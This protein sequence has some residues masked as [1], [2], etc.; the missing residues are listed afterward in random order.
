MKSIFIIIFLFQVSLFSSAKDS[1][2]Y[3][4]FYNLQNLFDTEDDPLTDDSEFLPDSELQWT[5]ERLD[6]QMFNLARVIR[7]MNNGKGPDLLGVCEVEHQ[8]LLDSM[9]NKF[10]KNKHYKSISLNSPDG[11]GI[12]NG[13]MYKAKL[14]DVLKV[15]ADTVHL[16]GKSRTRLI[17][18]ALFLFNKKDSIYFFVNHW[19][20]R[21]GG[22]EESEKKRITAAK[23]LRARVDEI[24]YNHPNA[25]IIIVGDF[26]DEPNNI[27]LLE[28][29]KAK[30]FLCESEA[31]PN[32][33]LTDDETDLLNLSFKQFLEGFGSYKFQGEWNMLDQIIVS[34]NLIIGNRLF[35]LCD[36]FDVYNPDFIVTKSGKFKGAPFPTF[37][38]KRYLG[39][40]SDH[41][42]VVAKFKIN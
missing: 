26:N 2:L 7:S 39:G 31:N 13:I 16:G 17:L 37:A 9:S 35:Y 30:P 24:L 27:S 1:V 19:P 34:R 12:Q 15:Y 11:R 23:T 28:F 42:P 6:R 29:L 18:G 32:L 36:S 21:R 41:F 22:Q 38:G 10:L 8:F 4:G 14:F 33:S 20:S 40:Y 25:N 3:V 5:Y